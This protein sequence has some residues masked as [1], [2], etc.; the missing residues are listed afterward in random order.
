MEA[1]RS[2]AQTLFP[3]AQLGVAVPAA[4]EAAVHGLTATA[5]TKLRC[6]SSSTSAMPLTPSPCRRCSMLLWWPIFPLWRGG[7]HG[8]TASHLAST[9]AARRLLLLGAC[10]QG[11]PLGPLLFALGLE[12]QA[13]PLDLSFVYLDDGV[14]AGRRLL[15]PLWPMSKLA[16]TKL[17]CLS[18]WTRVKW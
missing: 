8:A 15:R 16:L 4:A 11:D 5:A 6:S 1:V 17:A 7:L 10:K 14:L 3:P 18:T 2:D 9:S 13:G 12:L